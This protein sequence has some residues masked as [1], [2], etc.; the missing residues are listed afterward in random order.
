MPCKQCADGTWRWGHTGQC[1][2]PTEEA[3]K[4]AHKD[5]P[6]VKGNQNE[7][8]EAQRNQKAE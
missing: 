7:R 5:S 2:Y 3:C 8:K 1:K 4:R 6:H